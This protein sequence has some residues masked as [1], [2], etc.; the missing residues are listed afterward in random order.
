MD[1]V[2]RLATQM[3]A[4]A[5]KR[6]AE[7]RD[8][9]SSSE[10]GGPATSNAAG[11]RS[12]GRNGSGKFS[13][14]LW[15]PLAAADA[16]QSLATAAQILQ[17]IAS[18]MSGLSEKERRV[19]LGMPVDLTGRLASRAAAR[20]VKFLAAAEEADL[21]KTGS[22]SGEKNRQSTS[23]TAAVVSAAE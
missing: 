10:A 8:N 15:T 2:Q 5:A 6:S 20:T 22:K 21:E 7:Q 13:T 3:Q 14:P 12:S 17:W 11:S 1:G 9:G 18:E 4:L 23:E 16:T 19:A